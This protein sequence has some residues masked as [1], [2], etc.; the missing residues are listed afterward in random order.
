MDV[1]GDSLVDDR[2]LDDE[3]RFL[4]K[5]VS[6]DYERLTLVAE[7]EDDAERWKT[8]LLR[9]GVFPVN[10]SFQDLSNDIF[11]NG[12]L[13]ESVALIRHLT[14]E[15]M[16]I[17]KKNL[18]DKFTKIVVHY[19]INR[20]KEFVMN[21]LLLYLFSLKKDC[22]L[23]KT[24]SDAVSMQKKQV[25]DYE[26]TKEAITLADNLC[27]SQIQPFYIKSAETTQD[28]LNRTFGEDFGLF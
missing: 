6:E 5:R 20:T 11:L 8:Q 25:Q 15:Y 19:L 24:S 2:N 1:M 21:D 18:C 4:G 10:D 9:A 13:N 16:K 27:F 3:Y 17:I 14:L 23:L 26:A 7:N 12:Q 28:I 22:E